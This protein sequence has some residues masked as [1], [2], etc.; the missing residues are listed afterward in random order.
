[1]NSIYLIL[2]AIFLFDIAVNLNNSKKYVT[3]KGFFALCAFVSFFASVIVHI[4][5]NI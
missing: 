3:T 4:A 5:E 2:I 1:M